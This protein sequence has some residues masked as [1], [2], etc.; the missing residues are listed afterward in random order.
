MAVITHLRAL[1]AIELALRTGS[2]KSAAE[3]LA[4]SPA[5]VG[6]RVRSLEDYLGFDLLVRGRS[7]IRPRPELDAAMAHLNAAF[8]ELET[9]FVLPYS[10]WEKMLEL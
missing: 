8:R 4:I 2:M 1:Q 6:Q 10:I 7:G 3:E 9:W 5:A